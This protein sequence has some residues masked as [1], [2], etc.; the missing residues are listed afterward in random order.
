L[1]GYIYLNYNFNDVI[2]K[3]NLEEAS[4]DYSM[5]IKQIFHI[6]KNSFD[7][8]DEEETLKV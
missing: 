7:K 2:D 1:R 4:D 6:L 8:K 3:F 5:K